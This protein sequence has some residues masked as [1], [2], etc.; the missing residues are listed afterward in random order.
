VIALLRAADRIAAPWK[1]G[2]GVTREVA[3]SPPNASMDDFDWRISIAEVRTAGPFSQFDGVDRTLTILQGRL[4]LRLDDRSVEL[5]Q[6][7]TPFVFAGDVACDGTP[8]DGPVTDLNVMVRRGR[9]TAR[10]ERLTGDSQR[11]I[12]TTSVLVA[13]GPAVIRC[14]GETVSLQRFDATRFAAP[15]A[16]FFTLK[17]KAVLIEIA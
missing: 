3:L 13:C 4:L 12:S 9:F 8:V 10:T 2:G 14:G 16:H 11:T 7:S 5:S 15:D 6:D 17:G 1:N